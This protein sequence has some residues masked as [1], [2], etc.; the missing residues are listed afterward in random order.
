MSAAASFRESA[1]MAWRNATARP[2]RSTLSIASFALGM[3]VAVVLLAMG[4]SLRDAVGDVLRTLGEGQITVTPGRTT[5]IGN[6]RRSGRPVRLRYDDLDGI[7]AMLPSL[8][9]VAPYYEMRGGGAASWRYS[10][11][12]SPVR[13]VGQSYLDVRR[14][15]VVEGRW[16]TPEEDEEGRWVTVLNEGLRKVVFPDGEAVGQWVDWRGRRMT[17]VG[18]I[19]DEATF[20]YVLFVPYKTASHMSDARYISGLI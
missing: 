5:G 16:F 12:W 11:P 17:V 3:A 4:E 2:L 19:R 6:Q 13:A 9:G 14:L 8:A 20:P 18:V 15:P 1:R 10:I 7:D